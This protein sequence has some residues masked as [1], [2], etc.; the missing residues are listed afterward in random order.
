MFYGLLTTVT[1]PV[2]VEVAGVAGAAGDGSGERGDTL[3]VGG[4]SS[5]A[6]GVGGVRGV[7]DVGAGGEG[8]GTDCDGG[9]L[10]V[11]TECDVVDYYL[12][13]TFFDEVKRNEE[14]KIQPCVCS[15]IHA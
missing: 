12:G 8:K 3:L 11:G 15:I 13:N 7:G 14:G 10:R 6:G 4:G 9:R 5:G 1:T 2:T